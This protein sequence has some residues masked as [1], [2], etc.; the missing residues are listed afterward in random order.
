[1]LGDDKV[2]HMGVLTHTIINVL[3]GLY[4]TCVCV[5]TCT[6][7]FLINV[8]NNSRILDSLIVHPHSSQEGA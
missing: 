6:Y 3:K 2:F 8:P 7:L 1:M 5:N 4:R